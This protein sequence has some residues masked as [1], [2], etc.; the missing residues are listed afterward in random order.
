LAGSFARY[1][2]PAILHPSLI[3]GV[4][5]DLWQTMRIG[6][7]LRITKVDYN[8]NPKPAEPEANFF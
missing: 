8:R 2:I 6:G 4:G 1:N 7:G 3:V 5:T